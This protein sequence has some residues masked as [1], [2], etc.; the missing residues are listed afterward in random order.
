LI[1]SAADDPADFGGADVT[2]KSPWGYYLA[3]VGTAGRLLEANSDAGLQPGYAFGGG[4][5]SAGADYRLSEH[6]AAGLS[7]GY[8]LSHASVYA[9]ASGTVDNHSVRYGLYATAFTGE[10]RLNAYAGGAEDSFSTNRG[11][12]FGDINRTATGA[13]NGRELN[14]SAAASYDL[15]TMNWGIY[16]PFAAINYDHLDIDSFTEDGAGALDLSVGAQ[17]AKSLRSTLGLRFAQKARLESILLT[18]Y[19][20][21]GWRHEFDN[22]GRPIDAQLASGVGSP[23]TVAT[24]DFARDGTVLGA[25]ISADFGKQTTAKLDYAGDFRSHFMDNAFNASVRFRF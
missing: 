20:S 12:I 7:L 1:A 23:F 10:A 17:S 24:G 21:L 3:G 18:P 16:S 8:L 9:P 11:V 6:L 13:P 15:A 14:L 5:I 25:G 2:G 4:G 22:Q 19:A